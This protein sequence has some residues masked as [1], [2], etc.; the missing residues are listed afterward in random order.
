MHQFKRGV[1]ALGANPLAMLV[2]HSRK[3]QT[4]R[5]FPSSLPSLVRDVSSGN[6][7]TYCRGAAGSGVGVTTEAAEG[8]AGLQRGG[9]SQGAGQGRSPWF[10]GAVL[11]AVQ[12]ISVTVA[13]CVP[14]LSCSSSPLGWSCRG[15]Y[16]LAPAAV[17]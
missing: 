2:V 9:W 6:G 4:E 5:P 3:F 13:P 1:A 11:L 8:R 12:E 15:R 14:A 16:V 7:G 17:S 10:L